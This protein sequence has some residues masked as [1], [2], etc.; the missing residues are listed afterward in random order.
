MKNIE[1]N[2]SQA[3]RQKLSSLADCVE[4]W[5]ALVVRM[6]LEEAQRPLEDLQLTS[7]VQ[8][9][10]R[11]VEAQLRGLEALKE[12]C[13]E[14]SCCR[15]R[16][17]ILDALWRPLPRL[18][19]CTRRL[20][21]RSERRTGEWREILQTVGPPAPAPAPALH[22]DA[23]TVNVFLP[24]GGEGLRRPGAGGGGAS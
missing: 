4:Q 19:H 23:H 1:E 22:Q 21:A 15:P 20:A 17:A 14:Q 16:E 24:S 8:T 5:D 7:S 13:S 9:L 6:S 2:L 11:E 12:R 10:S 18:H 3:V